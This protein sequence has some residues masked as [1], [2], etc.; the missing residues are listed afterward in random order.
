[1]FAKIFPLL[2]VSINLSCVLECF[3]ILI[4]QD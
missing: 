4:H 1:L 2:A 3:S